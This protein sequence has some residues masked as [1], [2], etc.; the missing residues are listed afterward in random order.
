[1]SVVSEL[2]AASALHEAVAGLSPAQRTTLL[3]L[4]HHKEPVTVGVLSEELGLHPNS[5]RETLDALVAEDLIARTP[6]RRKTRGRPSWGYVSLA[7]ANQEF[8]NDQLVELL[9]VCTEM[10]R[11]LPME[12]AE[13]VRRI[14][15][16]WGERLLAQTEIGQDFSAPTEDADAA[17]LMPDLL[18]KFRNYFT[19]IG[20]SALIS[21]D[22]PNTL[23]L[24]SCP[25]V[26]SNGRIDPLVCEMHR[27]LLTKLGGT[28]SAG[29]I[30]GELRPFVTPWE[31]Q[32]TFR[33]VPSA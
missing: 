6:I 2:T 20:N 8:A 28:A 19:S 31:C 30:R 1:M 16:Q 9:H 7:P 26:D 14:G 27:G 25:F 32:V 18:A 4:S 5:V 15:T 13:T 12:S 22:K 10:I 23:T 33:E 24:H 11:S 29:K 17:D 21:M 3:T